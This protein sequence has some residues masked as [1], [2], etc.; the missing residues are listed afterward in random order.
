MESLESLEKFVYNY[1]QKSN[2]SLNY[3]FVGGTSIRLFQEKYPYFPKRK[4]SDFDLIA[5][6]NG[7][8]RSYFKS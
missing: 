6:N 5:F 3:A 2:F 4:I 8:Y 7:K 1:P